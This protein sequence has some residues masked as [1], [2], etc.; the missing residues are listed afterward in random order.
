LRA[1]WHST[2]VLS[3]PRAIAAL[4]TG[5]AAQLSVCGQ[6]PVAPQAPNPSATSASPVGPT[7]AAAPDVALR[8]GVMQQTRAATQSHAY[9]AAETFRLKHLRSSVRVCHPAAIAPET[10]RHQHNGHHQKEASECGNPPEDDHPHVSALLG[11]FATETSPMSRCS[12]SSRE[13]NTSEA[14]GVCAIA[15]SRVTRRWRQRSHCPRSRSAT[16]R[17]KRQHAD[18]RGSVAVQIMATPNRT[19]MN[20]IGPGLRSIRAACSVR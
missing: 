12:L 4:I 14:A 19:I 13:P 16:P 17:S 8:V 10:P 3:R 1:L 2:T 11:G 15:D 7:S 9:G 6:I 5:G 18:Q 20:T